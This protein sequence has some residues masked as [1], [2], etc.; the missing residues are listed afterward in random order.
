MKKETHR[1][2]QGDFS[3]QVEVRTRDEVGELGRQFNNMVQTIKELIDKKYKLEI[4]QKESEL[5]ILQSQVDPHFLYN[6]LDMIRWTARLEQAP[7]T[8]QLIE[9]LSRFFRIGLNSGKRYTTL[10]SEMEF[11]R[12]YLNLQQKRMGGKLKFT[13]YMEAALEEAVLLRKVIQPLVENSI[14][15]GFKRQAGRI[16]VRRYQD[17]PDLLIEVADNG[18]GFPEEKIRAIRQVLLTRSGDPSLVDHAIFNIHE[19][20]LLVY[21]GGYGVE[22]PE[23]R[24]HTGAC[25]R[26]RIPL[27]MKEQE[28]EA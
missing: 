3:A 6:T 13:L 18:A 7:E 27:W 26:L 1:L 11:V 25:V 20:S 5:R 21:G 15:Y 8:S 14:K 4:R 2:K 19:R 9:T 24:N 28:E 17:G 22:P 12:A 23:E 10:S 16:D